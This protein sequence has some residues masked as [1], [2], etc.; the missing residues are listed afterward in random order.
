MNYVD[1][2]RKIMPGGVSSPV[3]AL[4]AVGGDPLMIAKAKGAYLYDISNTKILDMCMSFGPLILGHAHDEVVAAIIKATQSGT[5]FGTSSPV[6]VE[7]AEKIVEKHPSV[8]WIRFVNSGTEAVMSAIRLA[9]GITERPLIIKF[10]GCYHGHTDAMLVKAGSGLATFGLSSSKGV[11]NDVS[12]NT[13]VLPLGNEQVVT[14]VFEKFENQIA[15]VIIEGVPANNG[16]LVQSKQ[17]MKFLR[18]ITKKNNSLLILDEVITGFRLG[19]GGAAEYYNIDPD[20]VTLG[21]VIGGGLP[22]GAYGGKIQYMS[23]IAPLGSIYQ[24]GTLSGN[25]LAMTAG[26]TTLNIIDRDNIYQQ[27]EKLGA[28][29]EKSIIEK[30]QQHNQPFTIRRIGSI[31]W[32]IHQN[33]VTPIT[34]TEISAEAVSTYS[35]IHQ[36]LLTKQVY[37][38]PSAFEVA[39][40]S[41]AHTPEIIGE[42]LDK[43][44]SVL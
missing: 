15:A 31:I 6:E 7:L 37:L 18:D 26:L 44:S 22:V 28:E 9:R 34:P 23:E 4:K 1:R 38:P 2:A 33:H 13:I 41:T 19:N 39:F 11:L 5:S 17:Y 25:P 21:K 8:D 24:A 10:E 27:L 3:R 12:K 14:E 16:L 35:N 40:L 30:Y 43:I 20:I 29:F 36:K 32:M 42:T